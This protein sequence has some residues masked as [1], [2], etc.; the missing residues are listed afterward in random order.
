MDNNE[1]T[2]LDTMFNLIADEVERRLEERFVPKRLEPESS[3]VALAIL[4]TVSV[5]EEPS[6]VASELTDELVTEPNPE[7]VPDPP[8]PPRPIRPF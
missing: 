1:R 3:Q 2:R 7:S 5:P 8:H 4:D 6:P